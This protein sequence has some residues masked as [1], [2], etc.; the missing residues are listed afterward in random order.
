MKVNKICI[1]GGGSSGWMT[2]ASLVKCLPNIEVTLVESKDIGTIGVGESTLQYFR[3]FTEMLGLTDKDWMPHCNATYKTSIGFQNLFYKDERTIH[4]PFGENELSDKENGFDD[5]FA[6]SCFHEEFSDPEAFQK[7]YNNNT[8]LAEKNRLFDGALPTTA[9]HMDAVKFGNWL[10]EVYCKDKIKCIE[11][12]VGVIH[13][14]ENGVQS[15]V[16]EDGRIIEADLYVDCTGFKSLLLEGALGVE[17][18]QFENLINNRAVAARVPYA[19][20]EE[21]MINYTN[22]YGMDSGWMW[23]IPLWTRKG[24]G[25][26]YC[27]KFITPEEAEKEFRKKID[28]HP[29]DLECRHIEFRHGIHEKVW[30]KNVV[31]VGLSYGFLEPLESTGLLTTHEVIKHLV[32]VLKRRGGIVGSVDRD[33]LNAVCKGVVTGLSGF[34]AAHYY[35]SQRNDTPYWRHVTEEKEYEISDF[36][37]QGNWK[38][39]FSGLP[40]IAF[41]A[42]VMPLG[43]DKEAMKADLYNRY[44]KYIEK[45]MNIK[46]NRWNKRYD[47]LC[48]FIDRQPTTFEYLRDGIYK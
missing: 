42:Q 4:Y 6:L 9:Y 26:V 21:E 29:H 31:A 19:N 46:R 30:H 36:F 17:F 28:A 41:G 8:V 34:V 40:F 20:R 25:Y 24:M 12:K 2:A 27:D 47:D 45:D 35:C 10:R 37:L 5:I 38:T 13:T 44:G 39:I 1:V 43:F 3:G 16:L 11:G 23:E 22:C 15:L 14:Y 48:R 32:T 7:Y 33:S 18:N